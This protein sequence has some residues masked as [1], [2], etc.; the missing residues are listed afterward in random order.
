MR[1]VKQVMLSGNSTVQLPI[2]TE[3]LGVSKRGHTYL[4]G[5]SVIESEQTK[6]YPIICAESGEQVPE[7]ALFIGSHNSTYFFLGG[8]DADI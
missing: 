2:G 3:F 1:T 7:G 5:V 8:T 6:E 4:L